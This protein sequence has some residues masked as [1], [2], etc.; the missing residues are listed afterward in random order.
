MSAQD[1]SSVRT[2]F[3]NVINYR[4]WISAE[5]T[6]YRNVLMENGWSHLLKPEQ[7]RIVLFEDHV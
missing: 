5:Q 6:V 7:K 4:S 3:T 2:E 1:V